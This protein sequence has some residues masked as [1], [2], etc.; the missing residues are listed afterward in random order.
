MTLAELRT[1]AY[2]RLAELNASTSFWAPAT[3]DDFLN[4]AYEQT[5]MIGELI[6]DTFYFG[7]TIDTQEA[8]LDPSMLKVLQLYYYDALAAKWVELRERQ[9]QELRE[10]DTDWFNRKASAGDGIPSRYAIEGRSLFLVPAPGETAVDNIRVRAVAAPELL[11]SDGQTPVVAA[12]YH[13]AIS[14]GAVW[15]AL[16]SDPTNERNRGLVQAQKV[17]FMEMVVAA[18]NQATQK[19]RVDRVRDIRDFWPSQWRE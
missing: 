1:Y 17:M 6:V 14:Q 2:R 4:R 15:R 10:E 7:S 18:S 8:P 11:T 9:L 19:S 5:V 13:E 3:I 16:D 12:S